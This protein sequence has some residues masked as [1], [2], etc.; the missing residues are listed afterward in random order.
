MVDAGKTTLSE[1]I[2]YRTGAIRN[3]GRVDNW[4]HF[5]DTDDQERA[6]GITIFSKQAVFPWVTG[7]DLIRYPWTCGL[8]PQ[9]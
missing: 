9:K 1:E 5:L 8:L 3:Q 6:R 2:L 7:S 4:I